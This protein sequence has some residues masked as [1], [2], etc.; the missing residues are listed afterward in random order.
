MRKNA[1][2]IQEA[3]KKQY[4]MQRIPDQRNQPTFQAFQ[5]KSQLQ[6]KYRRRVDEIYSSD[7]E[8]EL[9]I[10]DVPERI[11]NQDQEEAKQPPA[12]NAGI[13][14]VTNVNS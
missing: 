9:N 3:Q 7:S 2:T 11:L 4:D 12:P 8:E 13:R 6:M 10:L 14:K 1:S 5:V